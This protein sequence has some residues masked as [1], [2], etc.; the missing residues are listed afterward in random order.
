M[1]IRRPRRIFTSS[2]R[3]ASGPGIGVP[4][5]VVA[6][7]FGAMAG[8]VVVLLALPSDLFGRVP[9]VTGTLAAP[10]QQVAV[11][12][13]ETLLLHDTVVRL[14]GI[15]APSR[16]QAC[17][18]ADGGATDCGA[19]S[20]DALAAMVRGHDVACRLNGRDHE[21]F[22]QGLCEANGTELNRSLVA[23]GW[24]R[25]RGENSGFL[26][27]EILAR[28]NHVGLWRTGAF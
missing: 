13:G 24:A 23:S 21:G 1:P 27:D 25:A 17:H 11:V 19:A 4:R 20:T 8:A 22:P 10:T 5:A 16:G 18:A 14:Q 3:I 28:T 7:L 12:D 9:P 15:A 6:G 26:A 2:A